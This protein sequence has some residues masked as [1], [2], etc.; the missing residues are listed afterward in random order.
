MGEMNKQDD[1]VE[2]RE[3][4]TRYNQRKDDAYNQFY[5]Y[6]D[7]EKFIIESDDHWNGHEGG[8][9]ISPTHTY[10]WWD[11][12]GGRSRA[13]TRMGKGLHA[14]GVELHSL[15]EQGIPLL[16]KLFLCHFLKQWL[17]EQE[18]NFP[19]PTVEAS[20]LIPAEKTTRTE[21]KSRW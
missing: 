20:E 21:P 18:Y 10:Q 12:G 2:L 15:K 8:R 13:G 14:N 17:K 5:K 4:V 16:N 7:V 9:V 6:L 3:R 11:W 1:M 19:K